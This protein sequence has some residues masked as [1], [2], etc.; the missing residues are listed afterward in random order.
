MA[1]DFT[2]FEQLL[3]KWRLEEGLSMDELLE[4]I[5]TYNG[6]FNDNI[7]KF[8]DYQKSLETED[9]QDRDE[10]FSLDYYEKKNVQDEW[11]LRR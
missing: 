3:L 4:E 2:E 5:R 11:L 1:K 8:L 9:T 7:A 6:N 10:V